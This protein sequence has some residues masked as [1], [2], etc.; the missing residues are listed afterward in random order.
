MAATRAD[1]FAFLDRLGIGHMTVEHAAAHTVEEAQ[2]HRGELPGGHAKNLFLKSKKGE[3]Y[4]I[5]AEETTPI[6]LNRLFKRIGAARLSF[7]NAE[8]MREV[9][10]VEPGS[11]TPF[12][13]IN[14]RE[15]RR[16]AVVLDERLMRL[17]PLHFHPLKNT[18][19]TRI[20]R[21][22]LLTFIRACG[23]EP[24]IVDLVEPEADGE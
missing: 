8:L 16:V 19:T 9:L 22:D 1:L 17:D 23:H 15:R 7:G 10:G 18:A 4:L 11:V 2:A 14:D 13:L 21:D 5:V 3:L 24:R 6:E 12:A 20:S